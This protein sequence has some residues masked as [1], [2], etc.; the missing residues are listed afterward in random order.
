VI[1][2]GFLEFHLHSQNSTYVMLKISLILG[3]LFGSI[4]AVCWTIFAFSKVND[5][6]PLC[7]DGWVD[8]PQT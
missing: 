6:N 7:H 2:F 3:V 5:N 8:A 1:D 4:S